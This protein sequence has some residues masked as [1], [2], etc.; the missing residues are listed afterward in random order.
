MPLI[1]ID[2]W[3]DA[4]RE[5]CFDL[6]RDVD[7]HAA[8][9][10]HTN[11]RAVAGVTS[12]LLELG[13]EVTWQARHFG[14]EQR[15][16][17][18]ITRFDRPRMFEDRMVKGAFAAFAHVHE[19]EDERGGTLMI[20]RFDYT[21]PLAALGRLADKLFLE[22][23]MRGFLLRRAGYLKQAAEAGQGKTVVVSPSNSEG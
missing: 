8:S 23:Y 5:L 22:R 4:P 14:I 18:K 7:A 16:T 10:S 12:G 20:D 17:A 1:R 6:A 21:S 13:D 15:L 11:E 19:F 3:I 9:T 2:T